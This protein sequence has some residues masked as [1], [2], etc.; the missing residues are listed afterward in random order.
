[1]RVVTSREKNEPVFKSVDEPC[2]A[3]SAISAVKNVGAIHLNSESFRRF[4]IS[5]SPQ[6]AA[7]IAPYFAKDCAILVTAKKSKN[8]C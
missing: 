7:P 4:G 6:C 5:G 2:S 1:M 3:P 8:N